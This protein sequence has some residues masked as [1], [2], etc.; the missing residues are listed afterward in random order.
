MLVNDDDD[1]EVK[2]VDDEDE[3]VGKRSVRSP[4]FELRNSDDPVFTLLMDLSSMDV[5]RYYV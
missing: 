5:Y 4:A 2:V 1:D 3:V